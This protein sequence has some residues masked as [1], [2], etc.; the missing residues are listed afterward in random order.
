MLLKILG[1]KARLLGTKIDEKIWAERT[2]DEVKEKDLS[3]LNHPHRQLLV[4]KMSAFYPFNRVLEIGCGYG[5]NLYWLAKKFPDTELIGIDINPSSVNEGNKLLMKEGISN[6]KLIAGKANELS[7]FPAGSMDIVFTD[8]LLLYIGPDK[9]EEVIA[10][11]KRIARHAL[12]F[13]ELHRDD[14]LQNSAGLGIYAPD[15]WMRNYRKLFNQFFSDD[16]VTFTKIPANIWP[17][18]CWEKHGYLI[19]VKLGN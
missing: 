4:E 19:T 1:I 2:D 3:N 9:I 16:A 17:G 14:L 11:L 15:G 12:L 8:A 18:E 13:V 7:Q 6:V 5:P 10:E